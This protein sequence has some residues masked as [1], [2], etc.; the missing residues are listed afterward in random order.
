MYCCRFILEKCD[1]D[2]KIENRK[3]QEMI[4]ELI[5]RNYPSDPVKAWKFRIDKESALVSLSL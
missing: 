4:A 2:L 5:K 3:K 1:G